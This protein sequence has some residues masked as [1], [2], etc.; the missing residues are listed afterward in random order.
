[1][2]HSPGYFP[3]PIIEDRLR[4]RFAQSIWAL[5]FCRPAVSASICFCWS[6]M[7][8]SVFISSCDGHVYSGLAD[9]DSCAYRKGF[10]C[11]MGRGSSDYVRVYVGLKPARET[12]LRILNQFSQQGLP[13]SDERTRSRSA[14]TQRSSRRRSDFGSVLI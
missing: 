11:G 4:C 8:D 7:F 3:S 13:R 2:P 5:T 6:A 10:R 14:V 12:R 9:S 1:M